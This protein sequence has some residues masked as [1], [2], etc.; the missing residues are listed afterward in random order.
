MRFALAQVKRGIVE[1]VKNFEFT[2]NGKTQEPLRYQKKAFL[3]IS[4]V[5][6]DVL[7][8]FKRI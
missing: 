5:E 2:L 8:D 1:I 4:S 6:N 3:F 7:I